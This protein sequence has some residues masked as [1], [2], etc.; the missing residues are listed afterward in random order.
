MILKK[1]NGVI[2]AEAFVEEG[3][4]EVSLNPDLIKKEDIIKV[5]E[6]VGYDVEGE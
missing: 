3:K 4:V 2:S 1:L 6:E 5:I